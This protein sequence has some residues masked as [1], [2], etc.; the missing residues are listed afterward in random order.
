[1]PSVSH[2]QRLK[3]RRKSYAPQKTQKLKLVSDTM[4]KVEKA[5]Q[6][7]VVSVG[8]VCYRNWGYLKEA[9][10]SVLKQDYEKIQLIVS[11]DGSHGFP[12]Q[13]FEA[14]IRDNKRE[15]IVSFRVRQS[16]KNEGTV[17]HLNRVL[18]L[19]V[20]EYVMF[21]AADDGFDNPGVLSR[22]VK[23][24]GEQEKEC[25]AIMAQTALYNRSMHQLEGYFVWPDVA[26]AINM[27]N[28]D[29]QLQKHLF[30]FPVLP[31]TS[32]CCRRWVFDKLGKFDTNYKL[33]EDYPFHLKLAQNHIQLHYEN[34]VAARH[35]DGGISHG[36]VQAL[37]ASKRMYLED[38]LHARE[39]VLCELKEHDGD[40]NLQSYNAWQI[41]S[42]QWALLAQG[43]GIRGKL[44]YARVQPE[45]FFVE[46]CKKIRKK[47]VVCS[48][49]LLAILTLC[50]LFSN[51]IARC[52]AGMLLLSDFSAFLGMFCWGVN[53][54]FVL[55]TILV[56][57][58]CFMVLVK[59]LDSFPTE[60]L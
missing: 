26:E 10:D 5:Y 11:D 15:N 28:I 7:G 25:G 57:C 6:S 31:T 55:C 54:A 30:M 34:F 13:M 20:G 27:N 35:R 46:L 53:A 50:V 16:S 18:E 22:Y 38:C 39:Q 4:K 44:A 8:I 29:D 1:M 17:C 49:V 24:F 3:T 47:H 12:C 52:L 2:Y 48:V 33:I 19:S 23:A 41:R 43:K 36:A 51:E 60:L 56:A 40:P 14:Y 58:L 21:M 59:K 42:L 37:S 32:V 9:I 45:S